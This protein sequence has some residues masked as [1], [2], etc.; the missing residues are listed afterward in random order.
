V[1]CRPTAAADKFARLYLGNILS[2]GC[3]QGWIGKRNVRQGTAQQV[4]VIARCEQAGIASYEQSIDGIEVCNSR[5]SDVRLIDHW[6]P[7]GSAA[8]LQIVLLWTL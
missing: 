6:F 8:N 2:A 5:D 3:Q 7:P 1:R 4:M